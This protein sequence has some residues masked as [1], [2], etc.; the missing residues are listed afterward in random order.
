MNDVCYGRLGLSR[1][2][3]Y[4]FFHFGD[5][6]VFAKPRRMARKCVNAISDFFQ[7]FPEFSK[8]FPGLD[9]KWHHFPAFPDLCK[10][11]GM[12]FWGPSSLLD[13]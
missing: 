3:I 1:E 11:P 7:T 2:Y 6:T 10:N 13:L 8:K 12:C 9:F 5:A 4:V